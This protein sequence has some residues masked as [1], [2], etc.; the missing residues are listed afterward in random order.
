MRNT[1]KYT[2]LYS[3]AVPQFM[4]GDI[5]RTIIP[6]S[7]VFLGKNAAGIPER[8]LWLGTINE[9]INELINE[10][11]NEKKKYSGADRSRNS[12]QTNSSSFRSFFIYRKRVIHNL[13][14]RDFVIRMGSRKKG[15]W[16]IKEKRR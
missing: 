13:A 7:V 11:I 6:L 2:Q 12:I 9:P 1:Y 16:M 4:E 10:P 5:F 8:K 15:Y 3:E 14:E